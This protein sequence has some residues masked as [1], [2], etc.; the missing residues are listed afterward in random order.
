MNDMVGRPGFEPGARRPKRPI[1]S[2]KLT[3]LVI[4]RAGVM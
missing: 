3:A 2:T 1:L 4:S